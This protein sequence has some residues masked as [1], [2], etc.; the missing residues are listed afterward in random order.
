MTVDEFY[1]TWLGRQ[2]RE[3]VMTLSIIATLSVVALLYLGYWIYQG[4]QMTKSGYLSPGPFILARMVAY[5]GYRLI[6]YLGVGP[7]LVVGRERVPSSRQVPLVF[8]PNHTHEMDFA[9]AGMA[10]KGGFRFMAAANQLYGWRALFGAWC[11]AFSVNYEQ[12]GGGAAAV[13]SAVRVL[14]KRGSVRKLLIFP[15]G[16]L[17]RDNVLRPAEFRHGAVRIAHLTV[18]EPGEGN[19][20]VLFYPVGLHYIR[21]KRLAAPSQRWLGKMRGMFGVV[22]YGA[23]VVIGRPIVARDLPADE[24][25]ATEVIRLAVQACLDQAK[26]IEAQRLAALG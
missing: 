25:T 15:Q 6:A 1:G 12:K 26:L 4:S 16:T 22:N 5:A 17:I 14:T 7:V 8:T 3:I 24:V 11:G 13:S 18:N 2:I 23:I 9:L 21:D 20:A 19:A 10:I